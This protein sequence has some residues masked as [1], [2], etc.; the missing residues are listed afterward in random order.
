MFLIIW[1]KFTGFSCM[2]E[3]FILRKEI[4]K[5]ELTGYLQK[6]EQKSKKINLNRGQTS[7]FF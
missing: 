4:W 2:K 5:N 6:I 3:S 1:C 7:Y